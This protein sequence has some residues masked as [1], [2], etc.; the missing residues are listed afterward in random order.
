MD[1]MRMVIKSK[2]RQSSRTRLTFHVTSD[3]TQAPSAATAKVAGSLAPLVAR[4]CPQEWL[5]NVQCYPATARQCAQGE[6]THARVL[7]GL[8]S[9]DRLRG[10]QGPFRCSPWPKEAA[11]MAD[12]ISEICHSNESKHCS[13]QPL[14]VP[15]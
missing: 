12:S 7:C 4:R 2:R 1:S 9:K 11:V 13:A 5:D 15:G 3:V 10:Q 14:G 6:E 8:S